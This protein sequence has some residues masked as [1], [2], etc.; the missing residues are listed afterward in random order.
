[1]FVKIITK[2]KERKKKK[3]LLT[4]MSCKQLKETCGLVV[5]NVSQLREMNKKPEI[6]NLQS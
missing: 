4:G 5:R 3:R 6:K 2:K 1:M